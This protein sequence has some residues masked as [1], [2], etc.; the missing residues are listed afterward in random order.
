MTW[1]Q[2]WFD[3]DE[4]P[5]RD[6]DALMSALNKLGPLKDNPTVIQILFDALVKYFDSKLGVITKIIFPNGVV[7]NTAIWA[8]QKT[9]RKEY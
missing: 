5:N 6:F 4:E 9:S 3:S 8:T 2:D 7:L 1:L